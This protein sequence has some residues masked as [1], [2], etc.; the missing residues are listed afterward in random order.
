MK[1]SKYQLK[2]KNYRDQGTFFEKG[3]ATRG[4]NSFLSLLKKQRFF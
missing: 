4:I 1:N 3:R 2:I